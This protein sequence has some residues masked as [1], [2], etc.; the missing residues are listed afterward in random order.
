MAALTER[1][2]PAPVAVFAVLT[3]LIWTNRIWLA[4]TNEE[5]TVGEKLLWSTPITLFVLA[6]AYLLVRMLTGQAATPSF[7]ATVRVFAAGTVLYWAI[8]ITIILTGDHT[9]GFKAVHTVLALVSA[10]AAVWAFR[11]IERRSPVPAG[12]RDG[13]P[14]RTAR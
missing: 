12:P 7:G 13:D 11:A 9:V 4:W 2:R 5:D 8:R 10:A 6:A 3:L 1:L 14:L